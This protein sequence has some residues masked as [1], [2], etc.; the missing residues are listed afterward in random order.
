[1]ITYEEFTARTSFTQQELISAA[2]GNLVSN[3]K[4]ELPLLPAPPFLMF[5]RIIDIIKTPRG[6]R[7]VAEQDVKLDAWFFQCHFRGDPVQPGCLG[8]DAVWQ[9]TG[10]WGG[11]L[12]AA[13]SGRALGMKEVIFNGQ[14]RPHNKIVMYDVHNL[15]FIKTAGQS[16]MIGDA[17]VYI[18]N[19]LIYEIKGQKV[20]VFDKIRYEQY[21][22]EGLNGEE[23]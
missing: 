2:H 13:G 7:I 15:K 6:G 23:K 8:V 10:F 18:D 11:I 16:L 17:N 22:W 1:M 9:L 12:G 20:G 5:D 4:H 19:K 14:I 3:L 21:P